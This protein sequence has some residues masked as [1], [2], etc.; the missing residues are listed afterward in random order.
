VLYGGYS[1]FYC[2]GLE[3][4]PTCEVLHDAW[5]FD[6]AGWT[7]L[8]SP[9]LRDP[10]SPPR[11]ATYDGKRRR[12]LVGTINEIWSLG[13]TA[14]EWSE[15]DGGLPTLDLE[16][17]AWDA[18]NDNFLAIRRP[19]GSL[20]SAQLF[21]FSEDG[22]AR[23]ELIPSVLTQP[24]AQVTLMSDPRR[25]GVLAIEGFHGFVWERVGSTWVELPPLPLSFIF[26]S[27]AYNPVDG[28]VL[29][30][31]KASITGRYAAILRRTSATPLES[32]TPGDD[33][34]GD[35]LAGC[36]DPEC[37][38]ACAACLPHTTCP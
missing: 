18:R 30:V 7:P 27:S 8:A 33:L 36:D 3:G 16:A 1:P 11:M 32:C 23:I 15:V 10:S 17:L 19:P 9:A 6:G 22:W 20:G 13:D 24:E 25:G 37:F 34:D 38:W 35:G 26:P 2:E 12:V 4:D 21:D 14:S 28:S 31:G 29:V 5:S